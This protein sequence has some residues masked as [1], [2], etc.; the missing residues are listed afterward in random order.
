[1]N[2]IAEYGVDQVRTGSDPVSHT[3]VKIAANQVI[4]ELTPIGRVT[5]TGEFKESKTDVND[6]SE[7]AIYLSAF[8]IDTTGASAEKTVIKSGTFDPTKL[9][10]DDSWTDAQ[11]SGAFA[12]TP[13]SLQ[14][15]DS[16]NV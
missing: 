14:T 16:P 5:A 1:M 8:A 9:N 15:T 11:K 13:I 2:K 7:V 12:G 6:G 10:F 4:E 3:N